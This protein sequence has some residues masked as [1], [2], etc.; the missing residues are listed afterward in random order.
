[1]G[2]PVKLP[3]FEGPLEL[4]LHLIEKNKIDIY[5]IPI[6]EITNQYMEYI[7]QMERED[8]NI[9]SEFLVMAATLLDI[10]CRMLLPKEV[11]EEGEEED[12]RQELVEQLLQYKMYKYISYELRDREVLGGQRF[13]R[14]APL[15]K[16]VAQYSQ[17]VDLDELIGDLTLTRL[18]EIFREVIRRQHDKIDPVRSRFGKIEKKR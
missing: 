18:H 17:P 14:D 1:M 7:R 11:N 6:V 12:P 15:P 2:I 13:Y 8:L 10:K 16:E 3:V 4:L 5:D 9:M